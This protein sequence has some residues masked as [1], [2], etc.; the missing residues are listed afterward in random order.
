MENATRDEK[1]GDGDKDMGKR[2]TD[3]KLIAFERRPIDLIIIKLDKSPVFC[4]F[5]GLDGDLDLL[6]VKDETNRALVKRGV[7]LDDSLWIAFTLWIS[8]VAF[9]TK[10]KCSS[11]LSVTFSRSPRRGPQPAK[12]IVQASI[13]WRRSPIVAIMALNGVVVAHGTSATIS[14]RR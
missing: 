10:S 4:E 2:R 5:V 8:P 9:A 1:T 13:D 7:V 6:R 3:P 12:D 14:S 11:R